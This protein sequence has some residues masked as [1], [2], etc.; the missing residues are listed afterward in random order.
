[1]KL[2]NWKAFDSFSID[3]LD[4][5]NF[6]I[7][8][9]AVGKTS[10]LEAIYL[11]FTG[12]SLTVDDPRKLVKEG[13]QTPAIIV[14]EFLYEL[15]NYRIERSLSKV[16]KLRSKIYCN[17]DLLIEGWDKVTQHVKDLLGIDKWFFERVLYMSEGDIFRFIAYPPKEGIMAQIENAL[18]IDRMENL[19][20]QVEKLSEHY[21]NKEEDF[22]KQKNWI[23][24]FLPKQRV[25]LRILETRKSRADKTLQNLKIE[26]NEIMRSIMTSKLNI[27][28]FKDSVLRIRKIRDDIKDLIRGSYFDKGFLREIRKVQE[29]FRTQLKKVTIGL[30]PELQTKGALEERI[31]S[32]DKVLDLLSLVDIDKKQRIKCPVCR[33]KLS[34]S[35]IIELEKHFKRQKKSI[36]KNLLVVNHKLKTL[37]RTRV[38]LEDNLRSIDSSAIQISSI[39]TEMEVETLSKSTLEAHL[40][41]L[42]Q[43]LELLESKQLKTKKKIEKLENEFRDLEQNIKIETLAQEPGRTVEIENTLISASKAQIALEILER[44]TKGAIKGERQ[45]KLTPLYTEIANV[46]NKLKEDEGYRIEFDEKT[47]PLL[48]KHDRKFD[49]SQLSGGEKTAIL[50]IV[51]TVLC[52]R[53]T[54]I[55]FMLLDEPLEHLDFKNRKTLIDFLV[56]SFEKGWVDQLI[57]TTFEESIIRKFHEHEKVNI[58]AL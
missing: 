33:K 45:R 16:R 35:E 9:N 22:K 58:L 53:F 8:E 1:M 29:K 19:F 2:N 18:G 41:E 11:A 13:K 10:V 28:K 57:V 31:A 37:Q 49:I 15:R 38:K 55:G 39:Y 25:S 42:K 30:G 5:V 52:R 12:E 21:R 44:A 26:N 7:G 54:R 27:Q 34:S 46:W 17:N 20:E 32:A 3:F 36:E 40:T 50:V 4:G 51:R 56:E 24:D 47:R 6:L 43:H 48:I 23:E 14:I